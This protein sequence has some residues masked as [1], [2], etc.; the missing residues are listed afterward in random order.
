MAVDVYDEKGSPYPYGQGELVC[1]HAF[2]SMPVSFWNDPDNIKYHAAYFEKFPRVWCHGDWAEK[3]EHGGFILHGRSDTLLKPGGVRIG[4]SEI[5]AQIETIPEVLESVAV[6]QPWH[7]DVRIV[8]FVHLKDNVLLTNELK[9]SITLAIRYGASPH[10]VPKKIIA[11][12]DIPRTQS[13]KISEVAVRDQIM[14][15]PI[16]NRE[17]LGNPDSLRYF[18]HVTELET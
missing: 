8:L 1:T 4:T 11:V 5:Y 7:G 15:R 13:G 3:T 14:G 16:S 6:G 9:K 17:A 10:H 18:T 12:P 2:P